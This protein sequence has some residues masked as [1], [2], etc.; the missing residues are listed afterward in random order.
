M[1]QWSTWT[2]DGGNRRKLWSRGNEYIE[3][4]QV[5]GTLAM[6]SL[7]MWGALDS[8]RNLKKA[9]S[10]TYMWKVVVI[11]QWPCLKENQR[12]FLATQSRKDY[13]TRC[14]SKLR[15]HDNGH[16]EK[17]MTCCP[18]RYTSARRQTLFTN[19]VRCYEQTIHYILDVSNVLNY[20]RLNKY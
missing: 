17:R 16:Q 10:L 3:D 7:A 9:S 4:V 5:N 14:W 12:P 2:K 8:H 13:K 6:L 1:S 20:Y 15:E 18:V 11:K 19:L